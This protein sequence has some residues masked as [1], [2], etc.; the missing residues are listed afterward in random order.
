MFSQ[1]V[2]G[3]FDVFILLI[4]LEEESWRKVM[5]VVNYNN[6]LVAH[7]ETHK[8]LFLIF[9]DNERIFFCLNFLLE[10]VEI[11]SRFSPLHFFDFINNFSCWSWCAV[12]VFYIKFI[13]WR[14]P[15]GMWT[16]F[17]IKRSEVV[18]IVKEFWEFSISIEKFLPF[19]EAWHRIDMVMSVSHE[20]NKTFVR[21]FLSF[22]TWFSSRLKP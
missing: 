3:I 21:F 22:S 18:A 20:E 5:F 17:M 2:Q 10:F 11:R 4:L 7:D 8:R 15:I 16:T 1:H 6:L 12:A 14:V 9:K 19:F 13:K